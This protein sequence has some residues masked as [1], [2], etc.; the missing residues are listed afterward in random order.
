MEN[1]LKALFNY[2]K[3]ENNTELKK[4]IDSVHGRYA[5]RALSMDELEM[6]AAAGEAYSD[7]KD[8]K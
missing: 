4:V 5:S 7:L 1:I 8:K 3:F 6:V 2:Q